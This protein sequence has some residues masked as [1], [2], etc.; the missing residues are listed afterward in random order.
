MVHHSIISQTYSNFG[1]NSG[2]TGCCE[3]IS[4]SPATADLRWRSVRPGG[5]A[6]QEELILGFAAPTLCHG[7][8][9]NPPAGINH[10]RRYWRLAESVFPLHL[11]R[12]HPG[13]PQNDRQALLD[14]Q[15]P[16]RDRDPAA[17]S[18]PLIIEQQHFPC[19]G[20][21]AVARR[22][23]VILTLWPHRRHHRASWRIVT[24]L[25]VARR[26]AAKSA[27][28]EGEPRAGDAW[29][30]LPPSSA[31]ANFSLRLTWPPASPAPST[32]ATLIGT[33]AGSLRQCRRQP[34]HH[35]LPGGSP[36][37][38][39]LVPSPRSAPCLM[40]VVMASGKTTK[41]PGRGVMDVVEI[42]EE[43][44]VE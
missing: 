42:G 21:R 43:M 27:L 6:K 10:S 37:Q 33:T 34:G 16:I 26:S 17:A 28:V 40:P 36:A 19:P 29:L 23:S 3:A 13:S 5:G 18:W 14:F 44:G 31:G 9:T 24:P 25:S 38:G 4:P 11:G 32:L 22:R 12:S 15:F 2:G 30:Q 7:Q 8:E 20:D 35:R 39:V 1:F 41:A